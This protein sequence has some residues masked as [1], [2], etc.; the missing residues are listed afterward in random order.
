MGVLSCLPIIQTIHIKFG[1]RLALLE[2]KKLRHDGHDAC[3]MMNDE[4]RQPIVIG[5]LSD[6]GDLK[7][8]SVSFKNVESSDNC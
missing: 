8:L 2:Q 1:K 4:G 3:G 6:S 7:I 5:H